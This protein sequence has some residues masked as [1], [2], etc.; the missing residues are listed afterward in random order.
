[1]APATSEATARGEK[2]GARWYD[3]HRVTLAL[4]GAIGAITLALGGAAWS[5]IASASSANARQ[6]AQIETLQRGLERQ[7]GK[8][9]RILE[10]LK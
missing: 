10:R 2:N 7:D 3:P 5:A 8:L 9:D 6:D 1:M 4:F